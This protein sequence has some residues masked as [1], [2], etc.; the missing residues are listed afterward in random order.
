MFDDVSS[1]ALTSALRGL[2]SRQRAIANNISN[3]ETPGFH[4]TRVTFEDSLREAV[5]SGDSGAV[6]DVAPSSRTSL[7]PTRQDGNNVNLDTETLS[8][9]DTNLR[10][11][12]RAARRRPRVQ[13]AAHVDADRLMPIFDAIGM[14]QSGAAVYRKWIDAVSDNISNMNDVTSTSQAA[15]QAKSIEAGEMR[16]GG[17]QVVSVGLGS[18][19]GRL[20]YQPDHPLADAKG[21]V[22]YPDIDLGEQ[23]GQAIMAQ[24]GYQANLSAVDRAR[25]A[26]EAALQ[27]G[28]G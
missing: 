9:V 22:R 11:Q 17:A 23:M 18:A 24:R 5:G 2:A 15:Y 13:R 1:V 21:Y 28:K 4:A 8:S 12:A 6:A 16:G 7:E 27:V 14:A 20:V 3:I 19:E 10:Y 25:S 26:Y